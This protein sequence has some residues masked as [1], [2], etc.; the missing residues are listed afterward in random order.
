[1][2]ATLGKCFVHVKL[3]EIEFVV[4]VDSVCFHCLIIASIVYTFLTPKG[5]F[6]WMFCSLSFQ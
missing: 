1:M 4:E 5:G 2:T 3:F 6:L